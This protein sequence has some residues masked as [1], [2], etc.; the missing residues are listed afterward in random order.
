MGKAW[1][2]VRLELPIGAAVYPIDDLFAHDVDSEDCHCRPWWDGNVL[3]HRSFDGR[4]KDEP[5][6]SLS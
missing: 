2:A 6:V 3:V 1:R 4:E 5:T